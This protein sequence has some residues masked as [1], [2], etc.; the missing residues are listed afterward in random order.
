MSSL[1]LLIEH[2]QTGES[3]VEGHQDSRGD[4]ALTVGAGT[5]KTGFV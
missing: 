3:P 5:E 2:R 1:G 4:A